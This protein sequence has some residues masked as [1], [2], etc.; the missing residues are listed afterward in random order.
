VRQHAERKKLQQAGHLVPQMWWRMVAD[1]RGGRKSRQPIVAA[2]FF[3]REQYRAVKS[4]LAEDLRPVIRFACITGWRVASEV[5]TRQWRR[6]TRAS[7]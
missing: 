5:L 1:G 2:G 7:S 6:S 3:E 4:K